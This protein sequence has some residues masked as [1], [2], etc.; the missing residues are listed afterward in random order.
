MGLSEEATFGIVFGGMAIVILAVGISLY[1]AKS[2]SSK[3][4]VNDTSA[5]LEG[6]STN[7]NSGMHGQ[8]KLGGVTANAPSTPVPIK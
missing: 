7:N 2:K 3:L 1:F 6:T 8:S 4:I 5:G